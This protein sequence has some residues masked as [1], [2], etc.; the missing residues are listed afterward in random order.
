MRFLWLAFLPPSCL[1][2]QKQPLRKHLPQPLRVVFATSAER[3]FGRGHILSGNSEKLVNLLV[4]GRSLNGIG[5]IRSGAPLASMLGVGDT[6][7][8]PNSTDGSA[9]VRQNVANDV[10]YLNPEAFVRPAFGNGGDAPQTF[11][12]ARQPWQQSFN[13]SVVKD[14]RLF[15]KQSRCIQLR[16]EAFNAL[17][18]ANFNLNS[19]FNTA[20]VS[21]A[22]PVTRTGLSLAGP[23]AYYPGSTQSSFRSGT[24]ERHWRSI[25]IGTSADSTSAITAPA[26]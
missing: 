11:D 18:H 3:P 14:F 6:N 15:E 17:N 13:L 24:K 10:P 5:P 26:A 9:K 16:M 12:Y 23:I 1:K 25:S 4:G 7:G 2:A 22:P 20:L 8:I 21:T 19:Q